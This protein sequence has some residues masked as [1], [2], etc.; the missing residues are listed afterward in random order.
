MALFRELCGLL[1]LLHV[2]DTASL[3]LRKPDMVCQTLL[4]HIAHLLDVCGENEFKMRCVT[5]M[6]LISVLQGGESDSGQTVLECALWCARLIPMKHCLQDPSYTED[7]LLSV[8]SELPGS[9][10]TATLLAQSFPDGQASGCRKLKMERLLRRMRTPPQGEGGM[11]R[12]L[13]VDYQVM[14]QAVLKDQ[15]SGSLR[16]FSPLCLKSDCGSID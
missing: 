5:A 12:P 6:C 1:W 14:S 9:Q 10:L 15:A 2:R 3:F 8:L 7:V 11:G 4:I 13:S 16:G